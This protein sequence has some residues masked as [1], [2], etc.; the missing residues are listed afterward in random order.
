MQIDYTTYDG[1]KIK[2]PE[3]KKIIIRPNNGNEVA[4]IILV[5]DRYLAYLQNEYEQGCWHR[6]YKFPTEKTEIDEQE[7]L[8]KI[9]ELYRNEI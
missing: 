3:P 5:Y 8:E 4:H 6:N 7:A 9:K 1:K 2:L